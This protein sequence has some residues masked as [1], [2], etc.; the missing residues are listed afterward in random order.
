MINDRERR[1]LQELARQTAAEDPTF[2]L[3]LTNNP[4][5]C[6]DGDEWQRW[7]AAWAAGTRL[8]VLF[9][10]V[11]LTLASF[12]MNVSSVG[13]LL[14]IWALTIAALW[15]NRKGQPAAN[16]AAPTGPDLIR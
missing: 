14:L 5:P 7:R 11:P 1:L 15:L 8:R 13:L 16:P 10:L 9:L 3:R 12:A 4:P 2:A 6:A